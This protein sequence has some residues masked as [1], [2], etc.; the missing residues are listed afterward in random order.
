MYEKIKSK[1][2]VFETYSKKLIEKGVIDAAGL[3]ELKNS[4]TK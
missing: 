2:N 4:F 3:A 1:A